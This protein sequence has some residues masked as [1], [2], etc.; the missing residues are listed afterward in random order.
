MLGKEA[1]FHTGHQGSGLQDRDIA[2]RDRPGFELGRG[3]RIR[4]GSISKSAPIRSVPTGVEHQGARQG[5]AENGEKSAATR[6][7]QADKRKKG[8]KMEANRKTTQYLA[9]WL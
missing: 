5:G 2:K 7:G 8:R 6:H 9:L 3:R 4:A 1:L